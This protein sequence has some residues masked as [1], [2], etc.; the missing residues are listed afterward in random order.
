M[1]LV[2]SEQTQIR[3]RPGMCVALKEAA[4]RGGVTMT[5]CVRLALAASISTADRREIYWWKSKR[6]VSGR[7]PP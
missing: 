7:T 4:R 2:F 3:I 6:T 5:E 1:A